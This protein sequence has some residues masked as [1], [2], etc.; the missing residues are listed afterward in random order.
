MFE[1]LY[2]DVVWPCRVVVL[3]AVDCCLDCCGVG[4]V[5]YSVNELFVECICDAFWV[6]VCV[7]FEC[8]G[9]VVLLCWSFVSET[10]YCVP[11]NTCVSSV[12]PLFFDVF[13]P[14]I[15]LVCVYEGGFFFI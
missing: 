13:P 1:V 11:V 3:V 12:I 6:Q 15:C 5:R 4:F 14:D 2:V 7:V 8:Y 10:M 9:V